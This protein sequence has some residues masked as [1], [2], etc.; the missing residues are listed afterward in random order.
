MGVR[1]EEFKLFEKYKKENDKGAKKELIKS[2]TPLIRSQVGKYK[3]SGLPYDA[4]ELE[5]R[6]LASQALDTYDPNMGTQI[7]THVTNYLQKL[8]RFTSENQNVGYI[9][10]PRTILLGKYKTIYSNLEEEK[11][12]EP[13]ITELSDAMSISQAEVQRIQSEQRKDLHMEIPSTDPEEGG[14][15]FYIM[16][17][18]EDPKLKEAL[19]FVYFD[20]DNTNKKILEYTFGLGGSDKKTA[21]DIKDKLSLTET[22]LK[23]RKFELANQIKDLYN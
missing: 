22:E 16:P 14:F 9:P 18:T 8:Y 2:L 4:L 5:G 17:D 1:E 3:A 19:D 10:E 21:R 13:T 23:K 15:S 11:G 7:N 20:T 6:R 12:R